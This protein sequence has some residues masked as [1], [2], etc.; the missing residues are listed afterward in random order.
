MP[1]TWNQGESI[2][3]FD[4]ELNRAVHRM[5]DQQNPV[6]LGDGINHQLPPPFDAHNQVI[7]ENL[8]DGTFR[9]QPPIPLPQEFYRG[10][11]NII[12]SDGP[13]VLPPLPQGHTFLVTSSLMEMLTATCLF[14]GYH[15][16]IHMLTSPNWGLCVRVV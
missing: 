7:V 16:R 9:R 8:D 14:Q 10:N 6:N 11:I 2:V 3:P 15:L 1:S 5:N 12:D 4:T 13:L